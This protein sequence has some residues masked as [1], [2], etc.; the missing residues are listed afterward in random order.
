MDI[1]AINV[2]WHFL[3]VYSNHVI[4]HLHTLESHTHTEMSI[5]LWTATVGIPQRYIPEGEVA[6]CL[7]RKSTLI[8]PRLS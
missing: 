2:L 7:A 5:S 1:V 6:V 4:T 8:S 3:Q